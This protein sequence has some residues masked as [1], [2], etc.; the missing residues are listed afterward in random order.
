MTILT[1]CDWMG[2]SGIY[3]IKG[4][5]EYDNGNAAGQASIYLNDV[6]KTTA[7]ESGHFSIPDVDAGRY[8]MKV[9]AGLG[10]SYSET[11][12][13][14]NLRGG[15]LDLESL[16]LP[17]PVQLLDPLAVTSNSVQLVWNRCNSDDFREYKI[18]VHDKSALD[19]NEGTLLHIA[20]DVNDTS[21]AVNAG[22]FW[23]A[24]STLL[25][26]EDYYFR[27]FVMNDHGRMSGSNILEVRTL[28]WDN[29]EE[30]T[31]NYKIELQNSFAA[32]GN[33]KGIA[34]DGEY[35]WLVFFE[36][37]GGFYTNNLITINKYDQ[38]SGTMLDTIVIDDTNDVGLG[39]AWDGSNIWVGLA[40]EVRGMNIESGNIIKT[41][42]VGMSST[43]RDLSFYDGKLYILYDHS[44][45]YSIDPATDASTPNI[46]TPF[47][48]M[49]DGGGDRGI[50]CREGEIWVIHLWHHE[51]CIMDY[52]GK[53]IGVAEV[54]FL[55]QGFNSNGY[56]IP[57]C[58]MGDQLV[59]ALDSQVK[60]YSIEAMQ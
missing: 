39:L 29:A 40:T 17:V 12:Q 28:Q 49:S 26:G 33:L 42:D 19:E 34:W 51:I 37:V 7:D 55:Q 43:C 22:D 8:E 25:P 1:S 54:D 24:G 59:I 15:D 9:R 60:F 20:T 45:F 38:V 2:Y 56:S 10:S 5:T 21:L 58:F 14:I 32:Q 57:M 18:Y 47:S 31:S 30:F 46:N 35:F 36:E 11:V 52:S 6:L 53:H 13:D 4:K 41:Y 3:T 50:A 27:V 16:L 48:A 23:W 44:K